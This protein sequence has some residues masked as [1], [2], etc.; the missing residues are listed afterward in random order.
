MGVGPGGQLPDRTRGE[1]DK[2]MAQLQGYCA[3]CP[4]WFDIV[5]LDLSNHR[6]CPCCLERATEV[7]GKPP[8][9]VLAHRVRDL[10]GKGVVSTP[11]G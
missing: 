7:R 2:A 6:L 1:G 8:L 9:V 3:A 4:C 10:F 11:A 5:D